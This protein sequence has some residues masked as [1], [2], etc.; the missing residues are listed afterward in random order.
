MGVLGEIFFYAAGFGVGDDEDAQP[1]LGV[2][3]DRT[4]QGQLG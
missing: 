3:E 1:V 4:D 2:R